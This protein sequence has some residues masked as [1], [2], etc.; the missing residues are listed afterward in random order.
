M[1]DKRKQIYNYIFC[2]LVAE[3]IEIADTLCMPVRDVWVNLIQLAKVG[4]INISHLNGKT[5]ANISE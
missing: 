4:L 3:K 5:Y 1:N 2:H